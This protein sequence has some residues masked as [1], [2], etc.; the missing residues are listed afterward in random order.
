MMYPNINTASNIAGRFAQINTARAGD[1][2]IAVDPTPQDDV[3]G[4]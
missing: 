1:E 3:H 2:R 4:A